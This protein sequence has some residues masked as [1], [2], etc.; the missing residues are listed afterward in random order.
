MKR[1]ARILLA[2]LI[3]ATSWMVVPGSARA[4]DYPT[5]TIRLIM[6]FPPGGSADAL[7]R[8]LVEKLSTALGQAVI[9][10]YRA[11]AQTVIGA[12]MVARSPPDGY[13]LYFMVGAHVLS[14]YLVKAVPY[15][16]I[17]D[18]TPVAFLSSQGYVIATNSQQPFKTLPEMI[19]YGR[20]NPGKISIGAAEAIARAAA[21]TLALMAQI[22][23]TVV[24]FKGGGE[25]ATSILGNH[26]TAG[27]LAP[28]LFAQFAQLAGDQRIAG[29]AVTSAARIA[30]FP[31][32]ATAV[33]VTNLP[34]Y[35]FGTF[36]GLLAPAGLPQEILDRLQREINKAVLDPDIARVMDMQAMIHPK[37]TSSAYV[38][39]MM[40]SYQKRMGKALEAAGIK[41]E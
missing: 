13:T 7:A 3:A 40:E 26:I 5:K 41:P 30:S 25:V 34:G 32:I 4:G 28:A 12:N 18:F 39:Q 22:D 20:E 8:P 17:K 15:D 33:E 36:F 10:E 23:V 2:G 21:Q 16:P 35:E 19:A 31:N 14:P 1:N 37:D 6:P 11:G 24:S 29:L 9:I 27:M 38:A